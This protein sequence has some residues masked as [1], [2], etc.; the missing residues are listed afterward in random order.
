MAATCGILL[1]PRINKGRQS[2]LRSMSWPFSEIV[3]QPKHHLTV[4][5]VHQPNIYHPNH[6]PHLPIVVKAAKPIPTA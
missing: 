1:F 6:H 4:R 5:S 3:S 2:V